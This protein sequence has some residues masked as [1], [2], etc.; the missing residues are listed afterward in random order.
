VESARNQWLGLF[1]R[2]SSWQICFAIPYWSAS[3]NVRNMES[4]EMQDTK[5]RSRQL[6]GCK[7]IGKPIDR[8]EQQTRYLLETGRIKSAK[9]IGHQ[10]TVNE[11]ALLKEFGADADV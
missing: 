2:E 11:R 1:A 4:R 9:K 3:F 7:E 6:W 10:W 5:P 8:S